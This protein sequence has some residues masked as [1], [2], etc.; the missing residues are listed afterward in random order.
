ML[1]AS[2]RVHEARRVA[3]K[4]LFDMLGVV[5]GSDD[6][7]ALLDA[8]SE[9]Q[10][11]WM[12]VAVLRHGLGSDDLASRAADAGIRRAALRTHSL[13]WSLRRTRHSL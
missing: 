13:H 10:P 1:A 5:T 7:L 11:D 4:K 9:S 12:R 3:L 6:Y 8:A 2:E